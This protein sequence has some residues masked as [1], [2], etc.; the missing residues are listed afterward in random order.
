MYLSLFARKLSNSKLIRSWFCFLRV[1]GILAGLNDSWRFRRFTRYHLRLSFFFSF[2]HKFRSRRGNIS[3]VNGDISIEILHK[4]GDY[5][6]E[7]RRTGWDQVGR[8]DRVPR[9]W[10]HL[11]EFDAFYWRCV[12][13]NSDGSVVKCTGCVWRQRGLREE[14]REG[15]RNWSFW[16][17]G[18]KWR[19]MTRK[20]ARATIYSSL[21]RV[22]SASSRVA[23]DR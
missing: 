15:K 8:P 18:A 6:N 9:C 7:Q 5:A 13:T 20:P 23:H 16:S 10:Y 1:C 11:I 4:P 21:G 2:S 3:G 17:S 14:T 12:A 22:G 19:V